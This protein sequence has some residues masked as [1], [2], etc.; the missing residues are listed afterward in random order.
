MEAVQFSLPKHWEDWCNWLLGIWLCISPWA[1]RYDL[2]QTA[3]QTAVISGILIILTELM[4]L[5][6]FRSWE[7]WINVALGVWLIICPSILG[8]S[9]SAGRTN[10]V[11]VGVLI[12]ALTF[13]RDLEC[14][15]PETSR[16]T[17]L[18]SDLNKALSRLFLCK[19]R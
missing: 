13:Y 9:A 17:N 4:T 5:S 19:V 3:T 1:L 2:D 15:P 16:L 10:F 11:V 12:M 14:T 18:V 6:V 8:I 7:E